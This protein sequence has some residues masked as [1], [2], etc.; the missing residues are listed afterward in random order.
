MD[1]ALRIGS[2]T[3][4]SAQIYRGQVVRQRETARKAWTQTT[5]LA[6]AT[7]FLWA[8]FG[9]GALMADWF[10]KPDQWSAGTPFLLDPALGAPVAMIGIVFLFC[11]LQTRIERK[12][13]IR[14]N[15]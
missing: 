11:R 5:L 10:L 13:G 6:S 14:E 15:G 7:L 8:V 2:R 1:K 4:L 3:D 12:N 9:F